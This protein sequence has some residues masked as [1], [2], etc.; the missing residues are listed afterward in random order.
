MAKVKVL[1]ASVNFHLLSDC[2][3]RCKYCFVDKY[4]PLDTEAR[5]QIIRELGRYYKE[6]GETNAKI[7]FVGGEPLM[8]KDLQ[9]LIKEAKR[10]GLKTMVVTNGSLLS[11]SFLEECQGVL[12]AIGISIDSLHASTNVMIGRCAK[13]FIPDEAYY[14]SRVERVRE[15]GYY[16]KINTVVSR[17]N[18][19]ED[20]NTFIERAKPDRW[21]LF[22]VLLNE[23]VNKK[24][25][26]EFLI[27]PE[28][29]TSFRM[30]HVYSRVVSESNDDMRA[31][32]LMI[33]PD[34]RFFDNS[35]GC[36]SYS[37]PILSVGVQK[38]F[39]EITF[40]QDVFE[41]RGGVYSL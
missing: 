31:S 27:T 30:R 34:G 12:D 21:K 25:S 32:Y 37:K 23:D 29:F 14:M 11:D 18:L 17:Y 4:K 2:N 10:C 6:R 41:R 16:L 1:P 9:C 19:N 40:D 13:G 15:L 7:T 35:R 8:S 33:A 38:A 20:F 3:M 24:Y 39:E 26:K 28:D 36:H 5:L 22:Q